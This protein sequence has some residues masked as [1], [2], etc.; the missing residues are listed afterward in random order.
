MNLKE[1]L[2]MSANTV[3]NNL[4]TEYMRWDLPDAAVIS[5]IKLRGTY[6]I[7]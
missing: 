2:A 6:C 4:M 1:Y 3:Y 7:R 5:E